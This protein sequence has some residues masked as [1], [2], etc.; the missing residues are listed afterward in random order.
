MEIIRSYLIVPP[1]YG[2]TSVTFTVPNSATWNFSMR[3]HPVC[4]LRVA[5]RNKTE[6]VT[7]VDGEKVPAE[8]Y[9]ICH[10]A[11]TYAT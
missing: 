1:L 11:C 6:R 10:L 5:P 2:E 3:N 8:Y 9:P 7:I 4:V